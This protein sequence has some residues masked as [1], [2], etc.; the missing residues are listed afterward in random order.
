MRIASILVSV[1]LFATAVRGATDAELDAWKEK[2]PR[3]GVDASFA[4]RQTATR[5]EVEVLHVTKANVASAIRRLRNRIDEDIK[6]TARRTAGT[7]PS[8]RE[9]RDKLRW[10]TSQLLPFVASM[11]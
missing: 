5:Y 7:S 3:V 8:A 2:F 11:G 6:D 10:L 9:A 1:L 4:L